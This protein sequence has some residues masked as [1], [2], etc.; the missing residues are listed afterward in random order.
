MTNSNIFFVAVFVVSVVWGSIVEAQVQREQRTSIID[1]MRARREAG[2][3]PGAAA[4]DVG[5]ISGD[6]RFLRGAR[7]ATD[8]VG[9]DSRDRG[10]V[11]GQS[12]ADG[13]IRSSIE[14]ARELVR[15]AVDPAIN[16]MRTPPQLESGMYAPRLRLGFTPT[17][18]PAQAMETSMM[19]RLS[20]SPSIRS[21]T[22]LEVSVAERTATLRGTV[23]SEHEKKLAGLMLLF[24]PGISEVRNELAVATPGSNSPKKSQQT[25]A[26]VEL[27]APAPQK[28]RSPN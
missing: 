19:E 23:G 10:F 22:P 13:E 18:L 27:P 15:E 8:F 25:P 17:R 26:P 6:E 11:G 4:D 2:A 5:Q 28:E 16:R 7:D 12:A 24:E 3:T 14:N 9:A 1:Q 21:S 20:V